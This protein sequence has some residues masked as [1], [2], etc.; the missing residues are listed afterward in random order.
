MNPTH[1]RSVLRSTL[2][3]SALSAA[4]VADQ[5]FTSPALFQTQVACDATTITFDTL[6]HNTQLFN[7]YPGVAFGGTGRTWDALNLGGGGT[8]QSPP[9]VLFN[10]AP[11]AI[12]IEFDPPVE[13]FGWYN[14][15][16]SDTIQV[17]FYGVDNQLLGTAVMPSFGAGVTFA[18]YIADAPIA[19]VTAV[20]IPPETVG[21]IFLDNMTFGSAEA[22]RADLNNDGM[23]DGEDLGTLLS[24][25]GGT[26]LADL[27]CD[28]DIDGDDLGALLAAWGK[29]VG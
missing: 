29:C 1:I 24:D 25:W 18:G 17:D 20:G 21:T 14:P 5:H 13:A 22:C 16:L 10:Y 23:I 9:N 11:A 3:L 12:V 7:Q 26:G 4:A 15:S 6:P 19:R 2:V 27:N 8:F 28:G